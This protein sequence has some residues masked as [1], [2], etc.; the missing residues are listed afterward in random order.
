MTD[1]LIKPPKQMLDGFT[2][3]EDT[4]EGDEER[5]ANRVIQGRLIRFTNEAMWVTA[6]D[7]D[8]L[9][10][11]LELVA[12]DIARV[13]QKWH[14]GE[15]VETR[16]LAPGQKFPDIKALNDQVPQS[17]WQEGPDGKPRGPWQAQHLVYLLN[18]ETM[19]RFTFATGTIGGSIAVRDL[20]DRTKWMRQ[21]RGNAVYPIVSFADVFMSTR[22]GGRQ[23]PHFIV[24][25]WIGLGGDALPQAE[26][27]RL[28]P[29]DSTA[30]SLDRF[31]DEQKTEQKAEQ[32]KRPAQPGVKKVEPP[33][34]KEATGDSIPF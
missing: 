9:P 11:N 23:R 30:E 21:F 25:R 13:V 6:D 29:P 18:Q 4:S 15:P 19:D 2:G 22:F 12:V 24:K 10:E 27:I 26:P 14:D 5:A 20:A 28:A 3:F 7:G 34:A 17:E 32:R 33:S 1:D 31:A 16:V 8:E